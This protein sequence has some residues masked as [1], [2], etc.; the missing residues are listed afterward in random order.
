ME[1]KKLLRANCSGK[2]AWPSDYQF[3][4]VILQTAGL[5]EEV[6][7]TVHCFFNKTVPHPDVEF[8]PRLFLRIDAV[9]LGPADSPYVGLMALF[10]AHELEDDRRTTIKMHVMQSIC[11]LVIGVTLL[12]S[13]PICGTK[14]ERRGIVSIIHD[15]GS[16]SSASSPARE[17][18]GF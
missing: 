2:W 4:K 1:E 9:C 16:H 3:Q 14:G 18:V 8:V 6:R 15:G 11:L 5:M 7:D 17:D 13:S 12:T 10:E